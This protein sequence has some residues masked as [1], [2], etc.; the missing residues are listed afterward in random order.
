MS[1]RLEMG[2]QRRERVLGMS[3][4]VAGSQRGESRGHDERSS[5][6][7][8]PGMDDDLGGPAGKAG[9]QARRGEAVDAIEEKTKSSRGLHDCSTGERGRSGSQAETRLQSKRAWE[10]QRDIDAG[11][12]LP[13][14]LPLDDD[15]T[16]GGK[17]ANG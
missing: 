8:G 2:G 15:C 12:G 9:G 11:T 13:N 16:I 17:E 6:A 3:P 4:S 7:T 1:I 5:D 10:R 14:P